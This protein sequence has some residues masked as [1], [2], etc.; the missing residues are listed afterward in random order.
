[1]KPNTKRS[2]ETTLRIWEAFMKSRGITYSTATTQ[3]A[4]EF[5]DYLTSRVGIN[6]SKAANG[7]VHSRIKNLKKIYQALLSERK[8]KANIFHTPLIKLK[9]PRS[10]MKRRTQSITPEQVDLIL[11]YK[12]TS[13]KER[14][15]VC[16]IA[17][18]YAGGLRV[19]EALGLKLDDVRHSDKGTLYVNLRDTKNN[20][21]VNQPLAPWCFKFLSKQIS[22]RS[23]DNQGEDLFISYRKNG[24]LLRTS[25]DLKTAYRHTKKLLLEFGLTK[26]SNQSLRKSSINVLLEQGIPLP[27]TQG[28]SRHK[29]VQA[30][31]MYFNEYNNLE[32]S[33]APKI[34]LAR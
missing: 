10:N 9:H 29:S 14:Q 8:V 16:L 11:K 25:I 5:H 15:A 2:N 28:F 13:I 12:P 17:T 1:M 32:N 19:S 3:H 7:T 24:R 26:H 4:L 22:Q 23:L 21:D 6:G 34:V 31:Q 20:T 30:L 33:L 18:M 27:E